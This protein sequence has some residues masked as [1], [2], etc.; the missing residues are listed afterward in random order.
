[1]KTGYRSQCHGNK[2]EITETETR[3]RRGANHR[4]RCG[5]VAGDGSN[6]KESGVETE[7]YDEQRRKKVYICCTHTNVS[8]LLHTTTE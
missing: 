5:Y 7:M 3:Q 6:I 4:V 2:P 8:A 1:M